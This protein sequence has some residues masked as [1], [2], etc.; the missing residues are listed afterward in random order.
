MAWSRSR[1]LSEDA[2]GIVDR[3]ARE[4]K[5]TD[6]LLDTSR[7]LNRVGSELLHHGIGLSRVSG[8]DDELRR[9]LVTMAHGR[10]QLALANVLLAVEIVGAA[11]T[12]AWRSARRVL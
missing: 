8:D 2:R 10:A 3:W 9:G 11:D 4:S 1:L 6:G 12:P 7:Q 5:R